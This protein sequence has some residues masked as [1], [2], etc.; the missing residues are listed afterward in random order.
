M[1]SSQ[2][3]AATVSSPADSGSVPSRAEVAEERSNAWMSEKNAALLALK[4]NLEALI[5]KRDHAN[6]ELRTIHR[7]RE[8]LLD[9]IDRCSRGITE[10]L[11]A[12]H[13]LEARE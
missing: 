4:Q 5:Y 13:K 9:E 7:R 3:V 10:I 6:E 11:E 2:S 1:T 12:L 8:L